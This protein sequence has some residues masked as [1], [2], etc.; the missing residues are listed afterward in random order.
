[1]L[2]N[3]FHRKLEI[4][5]KGEC[6]ILGYL[7]SNSLKDKIYRAEQ[8]SE[9]FKRKFPETF[10]S[11]GNSP[12]RWNNRE[13]PDFYVVSPL[14]PLQLAFGLVGTTGNNRAMYVE[15]VNIGTELN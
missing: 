12:F 11:Y 3:T 15:E 6:F 10:K 4:G 7:Y 2:D 8:Y 9:S 13:L 1:M 14:V 5:E